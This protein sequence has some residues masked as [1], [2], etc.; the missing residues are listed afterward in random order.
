MTGGYTGKLLWVD[1]A[2]GKIRDETPDESLYRDYIG[3][4]GIG[5]QD[6]RQWLNRR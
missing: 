5:S 6:T 3:G 2:T 4:Y 1:L